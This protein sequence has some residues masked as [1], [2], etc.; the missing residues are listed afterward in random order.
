MPKTYCWS[1]R[2]WRDVRR[3]LPPR[4]ADRHVQTPSRVVVFA[5]PGRAL[6]E[7]HGDVAPERGLDF[8][9]DLGRDEGGRA[10]EM[11]LEADAVLRDFAQLREGE[12][13]VAAAVGQDGAVPVHEL[14]QPTEMPHR[15]HP[16]PHEKMVGVAEDDLRGQLPQ[17]ARADGFH[18]ALRAD[19]HEGGRLDYA[20]ICRQ[21]PAARIRGRIA[22]EQFKHGP[23]T[24]G[25]QRPASKGNRAPRR[26]VAEVWSEIAAC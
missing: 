25:R 8:H 3:S 10:V 23:G 6:V 11:V 18:A 17:L 7:H 19:G 13:L 12:D 20:M 4:P 9:R 21:P 14:V 22:S 5:R 24:F 1:V 16:R 26:L 15:L 2:R